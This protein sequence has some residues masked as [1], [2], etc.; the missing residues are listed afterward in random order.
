MLYDVIVVGAGPAGAMTAY[1]CARAGL[2]VLL[3]D[4]AIFPREK[5]CGGAISTRSIEVLKLVGI[6]IPTN[7]IEQEIFAA[8]FMGPDKIPFTLRFSRRFAYTVKRNHFDHFLVKEAVNAGVQFIDDCAL[9]R[10]EQFSDQVVCHTNKGVFKAQLL[11][12]ADG[13]TSK[14]GRITGLRKPR[15]PNAVG[16]AVEVDEPIPDEW[17]NTFL[18]PSLLVFWFLNV[19]SGYFWSFPRKHS[20]SLGIGGIAGQLGNLPKLLRGIARMFAEQIGVSPFKLQGVC[21]HLLPLFSE[22]LPLFTK[23]IILVGDAAGFVDAFS[24]QGI[25]YALESGLLAAQASINVT[26]N[27]QNHNVAFANFSKRIRRRFGE[28]LRVSREV[29]QL[30]HGHLYGGFRAVRFLK[31]T[32]RAIFDLG[33]G[34]IDYYRMKRN[35]IAFLS[36]LFV[37]E[38]QGRLMKGSQK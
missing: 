2:V 4:K 5:P 30:V 10:L 33:S 23:R 13:A 12:G 6:T 8:Q 22:P 14:V 16:I 17:W 34:K 18:D 25:C 31:C 24:G 20:L 27:K 15:H 29:A 38:L 28:E 21:G 7:I 9:E 37:Y 19:P 11:I 1:R 3:I 36:R 26:K 32:T 35:P